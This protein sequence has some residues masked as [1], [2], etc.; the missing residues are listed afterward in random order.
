MNF[1]LQLAGGGRRAG[2]TRDAAR[3][4][5]EQPPASATDVLDTA[6]AGDVAASTRATIARATTPQQGLALTLGSPELQRR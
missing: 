1:A 5:P 4:A 2:Q 6:L 3:R